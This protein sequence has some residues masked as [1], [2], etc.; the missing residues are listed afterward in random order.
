[1]VKVFLEDKLTLTNSKAVLYVYLKQSIVS[2]I[3]KLLF[4]SV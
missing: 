1:M 3:D 4:V 2:T